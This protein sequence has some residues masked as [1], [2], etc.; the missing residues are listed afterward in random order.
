VLLAPRFWLFPWN[1]G[2]DAIRPGIY[3]SYPVATVGGR[4]ERAAQIVVPD[5]RTIFDFL[6]LA[7]QGQVY[8]EVPPVGPRGPG[9]FV[10]LLTW[11]RR[12]P[13]AGRL[14]G[15]SAPREWYRRTNRWPGERLGPALNPAWSANRG[16]YFKVP[17]FSAANNSR[18]VSGDVRLMTLW[19]KINARGWTKVLQRKILARVRITAEALKESVTTAAG[20]FVLARRE[21]MGS[22]MKSVYEDFIAEQMQ[23]VTGVSPIFSGEPGIS[24]SYQPYVDASAGILALVDDEA[25]TRISLGIDRSSS[26]FLT[27]EW[28]NQSEIVRVVGEQIS[29]LPALIVRPRRRIWLPD[30]KPST[31][32]LRATV[33][34]TVQ[35]AARLPA[36]PPDEAWGK[37]TTGVGE[38]PAGAG[39]PGWRPAA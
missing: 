22:L 38:P 28:S 25:V 32:P 11:V 34:E 2:R 20:P 1:V 14:L 37:F 26:S 18:L 23:Q 21:D 39:P 7:L 36:S 4:E 6:S 29:A 30:Q 15:L 33:N 8:V 17:F 35:D 24:F 3:P 9:N 27:V 13:D 12:V 5:G 19:R 31:L 10:P 16:Q